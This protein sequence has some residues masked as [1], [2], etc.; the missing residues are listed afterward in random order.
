M[1]ERRGRVLEHPKLQRVRLRLQGCW[2]RGKG[3][4]GRK[5][6]AGRLVVIE[7]ELVFAPETLRF[8]NGRE[9]EGG[10]DGG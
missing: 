10:D 4:V 7:L 1:P 5:V 6:I 2:R 8:G 9:C 3:K